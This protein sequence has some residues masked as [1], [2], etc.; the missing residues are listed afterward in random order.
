MSGPGPGLA[1]EL[2]ALLDE[3]PCETFADVGGGALDLA[4]AA[5]ARRDCAVLLV[6]IDREGR[7]A[8][9]PSGWVAPYLEALVAAGADPGRVRRVGAPDQLAAADLIACIGRFGDGQKIRHLGPVLERG[10]HADSRMVIDIR[11]GSGGFPFLR[12]FGACETL[13]RSSD[14]QR[15]RVL[16]RP[17]GPSAPPVPA[18]A[19]GDCWTG[20]ARALAGADGFFRDG[21][22]HSL[23][24][25]RRGPTLVVTFDNLDIVLDRRAD[26]RP[27]GYGFIEAEGHSMLGVMAR[28]WTWFRDPWVTGE[29]E[30]LRDQG[31]FRGFSRVVFYGASMGGYGACAF[32]GVA[33]GATVFAISPQ[34]TL[35]RDLVP[36]E[37]RYRT[38]W[39]RDFGGPFGD[40]AGAV[41]GAAAVTVLFDPHEALDRGHALRFQGTNV[42]LLRAPMLG[43]RLGSS[44]SQMGILPA[45]A[46]GV[47]AGDM[48]EAAFYRL[49]RVRHGSARYQRELFLRALDRG[50]PGLAR[51]VGRWVLGRGAHP[52]IAARM[53]ALEAPA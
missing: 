39:G 11:K 48:T 37:T 20:I 53:P 24:F 13:S 36:W 19:D 3:G 28:G 25:V 44:L 26:R 1:P 10:L 29:F 8:A 42:R 47:L 43:H 35:A 18:T 2:A 46:R 16:F 17:S 23:L 41:A 15:A 38:A 52:F 51:R 31:F 22:E 9:P 27:W 34:T 14:G 50:R 21:G 30:R 4:L 49:L 32:C 5:V 6:D 7:F 33:P 45:I 40:A 12:G